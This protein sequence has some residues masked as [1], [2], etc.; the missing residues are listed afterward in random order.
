MEDV[1]YGLVVSFED[2]S[3]SYVHGFEAGL[4]KQRMQTETS[5]EATVHEENR[6]TIRRMAVAYGWE[7]KFTP[8]DVPGWIIVELDK[9]L[10]QPTRRNPHGLRVV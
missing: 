4:L 5:F 10:L 3:A 9:G 6:E 8:T 1:Q 7:A 2:Q